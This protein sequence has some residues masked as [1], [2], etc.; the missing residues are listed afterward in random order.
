M[1]S[2]RGAITVENNT[3]D[4]ITQAT[5]ELIHEIIKAN[6]IDFE[7][8]ISIMFSA[9]RDLTA[10]YPA[11]AARKIGINNAALMCSQEMYVENSLEKCIRVCMF[12]DENK[13]QKDVK[14]IYMKKAVVL[15][16]DLVM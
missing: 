3:E 12:Y 7:K 5:I 15:R 4:D 6:K 14:H 2:I 11:K 1:I 16:P 10:V 8:V 9:T 13:E